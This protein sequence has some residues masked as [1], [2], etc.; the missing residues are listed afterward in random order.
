MIYNINI[1][2]NQIIIYFLS[3]LST[4]EIYPFRFVI[5][6]F[7]FLFTMS[8]RFLTY[9]DENI[10]DIDCLSL[11]IWSNV[12]QKLIKNWYKKQL[13]VVKDTTNGAGSDGFDFQA[14]QIGHHVAN[15]GS[16]PV[17]RLFEAALPRR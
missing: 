9:P 4:T 12:Y 8:D 1:T 3:S 6:N 11:L 15:N 14:G 16:P 5:Y 7:F 2:I 10:L 13:V 17:R